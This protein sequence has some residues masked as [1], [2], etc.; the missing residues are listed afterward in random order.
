[1]E[2]L[3]AEASG[4]VGMPRGDSSLST[5]HFWEGLLRERYEQL[6]RQDEAA[7]RDHWQ[8]QHL[9]DAEVSPTV[10]PAGTSV[11]ANSMTLA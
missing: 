10:D 8:D 4:E 5:A 11:P 3:G 6:V 1:M 9:Q 2:L 7:V